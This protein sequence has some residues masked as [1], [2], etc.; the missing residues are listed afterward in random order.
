MHRDRNNPADLCPYERL[1]QRCF[2]EKCSMHPVEHPDR[3]AQP[4]TEYDEHDGA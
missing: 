4:V 2:S 3:S 1:E